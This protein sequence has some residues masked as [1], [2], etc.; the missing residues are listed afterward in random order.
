MKQTNWQLS[1]KR[2]TPP[3]DFL[4]LSPLWIK[5]FDRHSH[6][7]EIHGGKGL[8]QTL[9]FEEQEKEGSGSLER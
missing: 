3:L 6:D 8:N 4:D 5:Q 7:T 2:R 9:P 1:S